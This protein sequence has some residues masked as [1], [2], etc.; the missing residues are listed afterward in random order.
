MERH[1]RGERG[2][3]HDERGEDG[4]DAD[5]GGEDDTHPEAPEVGGEADTR[6]SAGAGPTP[7][8]STRCK[9]APIASEM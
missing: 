1:L 6:S 8:D 5:V 4:G 9:S 3:E 2:C 7:A